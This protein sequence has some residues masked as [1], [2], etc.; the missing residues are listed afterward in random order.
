MS[1]ESVEQV[2]CHIASM[3]LVGSPIE[4]RAAVLGN[5]RRELRAACWDRR[6]A[7]AA[8]VL[9]GLGI[10]LNA[11]IGQPAGS[12]S[13]NVPRARRSEPQLSLV[14]TAIAVAQATDGPTGE[15]VVRQLA[16]MTGRE[17]TVEEVVAIETA[18]RRPTSRKTPKNRG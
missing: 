2:G 17:L 4:L 16:A 7:R 9:L 5:I 10:G 14:D 1:D 15:Q 6:M 8:T 12:G 13:G 3:R 18:L 11:A